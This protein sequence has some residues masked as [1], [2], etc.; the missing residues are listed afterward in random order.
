VIDDLEELTWKRDVLCYR[1]DA[2]A[3]SLTVESDSSGRGLMLA[4]D[5]F[6]RRKRSYLS[7]P[8]AVGIADAEG[9]QL[10]RW[11]PP[12]FHGFFCAECSAPYCN[13]CWT[14]EAPRYEDG[15][16]AGTPGICPV[17]HHALVDP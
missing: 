5:G 16:Y 2:V 11:L 1:C 17:G 10:L 7:E 12:S 9:A 14:V 15:E 4:M 6:L 13:R 3:V 8:G